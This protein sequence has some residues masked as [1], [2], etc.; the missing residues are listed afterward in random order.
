L[1]VQN[2][3]SSDSGVYKC[4]LSNELGTA[5]AN[6]VIKVAGKVYLKI[7]IHSIQMID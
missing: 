2:L 3:A 4:T 7:N 6:V 1:F 5:V